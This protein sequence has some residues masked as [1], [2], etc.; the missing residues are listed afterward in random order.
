MSPK[1]LT[2]EQRLQVAC[3]CPKGVNSRTGW[4]IDLETHHA[5]CSHCGKPSPRVVLRQCIECEDEFVMPLGPKWVAPFWV[6]HDGE[7]MEREFL[8]IPCYGDEIP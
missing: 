4:T 1:A 8:C 7:T 2:A 6:T 3:F 5:V